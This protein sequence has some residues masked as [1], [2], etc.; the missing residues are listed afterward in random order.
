MRDDGDYHYIRLFTDRLGTG[1][2]TPPGAELLAFYDEQ[3]HDSRAWFMQSALGGREPWGGY[4]RYRMIYC[5]D[6]VNKQLRL[7]SVEGQIVGA[8]P[9]SNRVEYTVETRDVGGEKTE[10]HRVKDLA[11]GQTQILSSSA[12]LPADNRPALVAAR[13]QSR[14]AAAGYQEMLNAATARLQQSGAR[15]VS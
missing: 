6:V 7:I 11:N 13:Q 12:L 14:I 3:I 2:R 1:I 5:G 15:I 8:A 10:V 9:T 4:F